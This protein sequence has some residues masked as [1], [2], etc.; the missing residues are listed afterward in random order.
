MR[1]VVVA[2]SRK[3]DPQSQ[4][5]IRRRIR[6]A[7]QLHFDMG[8]DDIQLVA[9]GV[10]PRTTSGKVRRQQTRRTYEAGEFAAASSQVSG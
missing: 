6:E 10:I 7:C 5:E 1:I 3:R 2:E 9:P 8:P 4:D